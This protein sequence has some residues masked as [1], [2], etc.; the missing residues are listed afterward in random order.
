[1]V[2]I[3][4]TFYSL[5][6]IIISNYLDNKVYENDSIQADHNV[7]LKYLKDYLNILFPFFLPCRQPSLEGKKINNVIYN[8]GITL[9]FFFFFFFLGSS[10]KHGY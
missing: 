10:S 4:Y 3:Y 6:Y 1:M 5:D 7:S 2:Y 9:F 8:K